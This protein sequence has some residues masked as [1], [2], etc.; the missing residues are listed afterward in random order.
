MISGERFWPFCWTIQ[1]C[2]PGQPGQKLA[3]YSFWTGSKSPILGWAPDASL[4]S[5]ITGVGLAILSATGLCSSDWDGL[6]VPALPSER[7]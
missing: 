4:L 2:F 5:G 6:L 1:G 7:R 3:G